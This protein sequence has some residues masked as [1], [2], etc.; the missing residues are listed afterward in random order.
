MQMLQDFVLIIFHIF[1]FCLIVCSVCQ[2]QRKNAGL[3]SLS[4]CGAQ[5]SASG[6]QVCQQ[7]LYLLS[8]LTTTI[9]YYYY[10]FII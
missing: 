8:H 1:I 9:S 4:M 6:H 5:G 7:G 3:C 10:H 2:S